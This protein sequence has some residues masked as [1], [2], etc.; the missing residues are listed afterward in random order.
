MPSDIDPNTSTYREEVA[1]KVN[2]KRNNI[3]NRAR[4]RPESLLFVAEACL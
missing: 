2:S 4:H 3:A 1:E